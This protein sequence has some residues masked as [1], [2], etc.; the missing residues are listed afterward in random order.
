ML[1]RRL[2]GQIEP[3]LMLTAPGALL[4]CTKPIGYSS[5]YLT[6]RIGDFVP[7]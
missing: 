7:I 6:Y 3:Y 1:R 5:S 4:R 2:A